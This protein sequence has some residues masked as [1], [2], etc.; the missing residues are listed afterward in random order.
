M[1]PLLIL[2]SFLVLPMIIFFINLNFDSDGHVYQGDWVNDLRQ[3][4]G[5][6]K[7]IDGTIY[8]VSLRVAFLCNAIQIFRFC[9]QRLFY[10]V[11][12]ELKQGQHW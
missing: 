7:F 11:N 4:H 6:M 8:G 12:R 1:I 9:R 5:I 3:G 10:S 2:M